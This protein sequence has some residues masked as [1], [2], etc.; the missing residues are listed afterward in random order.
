MKKGE[1]HIGTSGW[2]Y[3]HWIGVFYPRGMPEREKLEFFAQHFDTVEINFS[4]YKLPNVKTFEHW[5]EITPRGF[6][7]SVK[8]SRYITHVKRLKDVRSSWLA[9]LGRAQKLGNKLGPIL[10]QFPQTFKFSKDNFQRLIKFLTLK[11]NLD[12][13]LAFEFRDSSWQVQEV[14]KL[15]KKHD[16]AFVLADSPGAR[17]QEIITAPFVYVRMHGGKKMSGSKYPEKELQDLARKIRE[18]SRKGIG[19]YVYFNNDVR[20][21]AIE[22]ARDLISFIG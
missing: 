19:S 4:F 7:F 1:I 8:A 5:R 10:L 14:F 17:F 15:L 20:G 21:F 13:K 22:N 3:E 12:F 16:A 11:K 6:I 2:I 9:F 18:W